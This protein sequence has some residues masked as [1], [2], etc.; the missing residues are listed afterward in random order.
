MHLILRRLRALRGEGGYAM[1]AVMAVMFTASLAAVAAVYATDSDMQQGVTDRDKKGA[2]AAAEAGVNDY[3]ARLIANVDYWQ[4]CASPQAQTKNPSL[5]RYWNG[6]GPDNRR[7][8][9]VPGTSAEYAVEMLP[10]NN[11]S[12]CNQAAAQSTLIDNTTGTFRIRATGRVKE[13]GEKRSL[14]ATFKRRGFLDY[15]YFTDYET[16]A[17]ELMLS[18]QNVLGLPTRYSAGDTRTIVDWARL[19]CSKWYREG[20]GLADNDFPGEVLWDGTWTNYPNDPGCAEIQFISSGTSVD[21]QRG[22]FHTNDEILICGNPI[23]GRK[24]ADD[25]EVSAPSPPNGAGGTYGSSTGWR[26]CSG[27]GT[28]QVNDPADTTPDPNLGTWRKGSPIVTLPPS[29]G[30]LK[31]DALPAYR[32][33]G[34]THIK[35]NT[36]TMTVW[37]RRENGQPLQGATIPMPVDGVVYVG[38]DPGKPC[39][40]HNV[41]NPNVPRGTPAATAQATTIDSANGCGDLTLNGTYARNLTLTAQNDIVVDEDVKRSG[42]VMLGLIATQWVRVYHPTTANG[43]NCGENASSGPFSIQIDAAILAIQKSFTVDRYWCG[44]RIGTLSVDGAIAQ[45]YRGPVGRGDSGY[46]KDYEYDDRLRFRSPPRFL[47]PVQASWKLQSQV[48]QV[49]AT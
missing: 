7:W 21:R 10:G 30:A 25:I 28:P 44:D 1:V 17:P 11:A 18:D 27:G 16:F 37:G 13:T 23:F 9:K 38:N 49:P 26:T 3:L 20:R 39:N 34:N 43:Y 47:D 12:E 22:P 8:S 24:P 31:D 40:G 41:V 35:L 48:E 15:V 32:F 14:I 5:S 29:N 45:K 46:I 36:T 6:S 2:Y 4:N 42:D 19:N 33:I